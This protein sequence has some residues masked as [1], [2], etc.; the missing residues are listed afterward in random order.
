[1][2]VTMADLA[3]C[4]PHLDEHLREVLTERVNQAPAPCR[5][6][7]DSIPAVVVDGDRR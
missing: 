7:L 4:F 6:R 5:Q 3:S 1:M 2:V